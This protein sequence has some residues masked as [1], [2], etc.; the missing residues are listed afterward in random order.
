MFYFLKAGKENLQHLTLIKI[1]SQNLVYIAAWENM[2][3]VER[4]TIPVAD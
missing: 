4:D 2:V 3:A 1:A